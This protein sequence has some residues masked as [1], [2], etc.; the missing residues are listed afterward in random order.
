MIRLTQ[1]NG[2]EIIVN[3]DL[4]ETIERAHDTIIT[5]TTSRKIRVSN[6]IEE[7]IDRVVEYKRRIANPTIKSE[8]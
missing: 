6:T 5:L 1:V 7:I 4:I 3:A 2:E 8:S